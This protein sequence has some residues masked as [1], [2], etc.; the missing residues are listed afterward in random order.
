[1]RHN[2][3]M[4]SSVRRNSL[5]KRKPIVPT[6]PVKVTVTK[7]FKPKPKVVVKKPKMVQSVPTRKPIVPT[8][9]IPQAVKTSAPAKNVQETKGVLLH[10]SDILNEM[11]ASYVSYEAALIED[12]YETLE[13]LREV[14]LDELLEVGMKKGHAKRFLKFIQNLP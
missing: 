2:L 11:G 7:S 4:K 5:K 1:V 6:K 13:E 10:L 8:K 9:P 14:D 3:D 12:G